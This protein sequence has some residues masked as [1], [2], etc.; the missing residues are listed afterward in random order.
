ML[1]C[2]SRVSRSAS[3]ILRRSRTELRRAG[4]AR[5]FGFLGP[6][7]AGKTTTIRMI[8][9]ITAP[10]RASIELF[11]ETDVRRHC[12]T[13]SAICPRNAGFTKK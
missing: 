6:N 10:D 12:R 3:A 9:G 5:V 8:V 11:G 7:G 1:R 13:A 4:G 2:G